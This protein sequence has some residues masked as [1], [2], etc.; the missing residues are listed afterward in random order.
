MKTDTGTVSSLIG[1]TSLIFGGGSMLLCS[2]PW[3]D[4]F[5][6]MGSMSVLVGV[7]CTSGW[8]WLD[9]RRAFTG[10]QAR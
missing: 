1:C 7:F 4:F 3:G 6:A 8:L 9:R 10:N 2:L 5:L